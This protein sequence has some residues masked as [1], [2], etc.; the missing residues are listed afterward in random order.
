M[1]HVSPGRSL[2]GCHTSS[3]PRPRWQSSRSRVPAGAA[4]ARRRS[5]STRR[6][7]RP[8]T[9]LPKTTPKNLSRK[10]GKS[11]SATKIRARRTSRPTK[12][13]D[14][15]DHDVL[16]R[17]HAD[18]ASRSSASTVT[19]TVTVPPARPVTGRRADAGARRRPERFR[20]TLLHN[21]DGESKYVVGDSIANY[22]GIT[23][24]KTVLDRL[25]TEAATDRV[26]GRR[27]QGHGHGQL[28][29]QLPR[30]PEPAR[31]LPALRRRHRARSTTRT[32]SPRSATTPSRS[33]TTSTTSARPAWRSSSPASAA[34][35]PFL[36]ANTDFTGEPVLQA[37]RDKGRIAD[38]VVVEKGGQRI[39]IIGVS[40]PETPTISSP[41]NVKFDADVAGHRQ[42][43]G[44]APDRRRRQQDHPVL[45]PAGHGQR[46]RGGRAARERRHRHLRRRRRPA[47]QPRRPAR[48]GP[49]SPGAG[50]PVPADRSRT[51]R[52]TNVP[53][54]TTQ[55]EYRYLGRLTVT[56][57]AAGNIESTDTTKS[58][59]VRITAD[60]A[61]PGL[62]RPRTRR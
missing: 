21:N 43:R 53:L 51:A 9:A 3:A 47:G 17:R 14:P 55:G 52:A 54:V 25:R 48:P 24:F 40:P 2:F 8:V 58:G 16:Q 62:R 60:P 32:R 1:P 18:A 10:C 33:A 37:L 20:L 7:S 49:D 41:R 61:Q 31:V 38:S 22:G 11:K 56:F 4:A 36:S 5:R 30:R 29:R 39:G 12:N 26:A 57:D 44:A 59:P 27:R 45:A 46:A 34:A 19:K 42:R 28:G 6:R 15:H 23:R 35:C 50:R 13:R